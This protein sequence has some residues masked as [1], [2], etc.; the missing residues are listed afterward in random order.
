M[1]RKTE[2]LLES[3]RKKNLLHILKS[4]LNEFE[5]IDICIEL[6]KFISELESIE[7]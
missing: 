7:V 4:E 5:N 3:E 1:N 2:K 6:E